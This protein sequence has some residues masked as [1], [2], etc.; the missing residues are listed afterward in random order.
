[1]LSHFLT[2]LKKPSLKNNHS[3]AILYIIS[4]ALYIQS[5]QD[6]QV[7]DTLVSFLRDSHLLDEKESLADEKKLFYQQKATFEK[8]RRSFTEAAIRLGHEVYLLASQEYL[9]PNLELIVTLFCTED[10]LHM[11][12]NAT[13]YHLHISHNTTESETNIRDFLTL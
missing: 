8:E 2:K 10:H 3:T 1:M 11:S 12:H 6:N 4:N 5:V 9:T 13:E 7:D